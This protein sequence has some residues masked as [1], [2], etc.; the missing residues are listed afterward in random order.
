MKWAIWAPLGEAPD[1][2][3]AGGLDASTEVPTWKPERGQVGHLILGAY[4][5]LPRRI[6]HAFTATKWDIARG[7]FLGYRARWREVPDMVGDVD[8]FHEVSR[9]P[10]PRALDRLPSPA[11]IALRDRLIEEEVD[12]ELRVAL[13]QLR[14]VLQV[15]GTDLETVADLLVQA[16]DGMIDSLYV[17]IGMGIDLG[18]P[19]RELWNE[20][21]R[22][23]MA[24][25]H[26]DGTIHKRGDG[27]ILKPDGWRAPNLRPILG[28]RED[29]DG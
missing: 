9:L 24:K 17:V 7:H 5:K 3:L 29:D 22:T 16:A 15:P 6:V 25:I 4:P 12:D 20:V 27:K 2:L 18:M 19:V 28:L 10:R 26:P 1:L 8:A 13:H 23:N 11:V 14:N 21:Q